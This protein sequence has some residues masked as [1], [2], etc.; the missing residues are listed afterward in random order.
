MV[1]YDTLMAEDNGGSLGN[2]LA[3]ATQLGFLIALPLIALTLLG[4]FLDTTLGT[5]PW[6]LLTGSIAGIVVAT[7][8]VF[9]RIAGIFAEEADRNDNEYSDGSNA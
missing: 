2:T 9:R 8:I 7:I 4:R 1:Y 3:F 5:A 6:L